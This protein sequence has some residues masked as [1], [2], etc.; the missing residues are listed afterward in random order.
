[1]AVQSYMDFVSDAASQ[2]VFERQDAENLSTETLPEN[3][4]LLDFKAFASDYP[5]KLFS[6]L[7][8][9]RPEFQEIFVEFYI[10]QKSQSF[11]ARLHGFI[12]TRAWQQL[13][14]IEQTIGALI[15]L[16]THPTES[17]IRPILEKAN[18][19]TT[20]YG[21]LAKMIVLYAATQDYVVVA[22]KIHIPVP[23]VRKLFRPIIATLL[24]D[25]DVRA[26][27]VGAYLRNLTHNASLHG[28]GLSNSCL[29]RLKRIG[30]FKFTASA[31]DQ[32]PLWSFGPIAL[33][34]DNPWYMFELASPNGLEELRPTITAQLQRACNSKTAIQVF[35]PTDPNGSLQFG[36]ILVRS[37]H[38]GI[39]RSLTKIRGISEMAARYTPEGEF[40]SA[41]TV[42]HS[43]LKDT[44]KNYKP[45]VQE[46]LRKGDFVQV[47]TGPASGYYGTIS[48]ITTR[49]VVVTVNFPTSR[50]LQ[51]FAQPTALRHEDV[52]VKQRAFWGI[53]N[54]AS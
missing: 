46:R 43:D 47:L 1:M 3:A 40:Q 16:G 17:T 22:K 31:T 30:C 13:R 51:I 38:P 32:S 20:P 18:V 45:A 35:A 29:A 11:I 49:K 42:P 26:V 34:Q 54:A 9:L 2:A 10:L 39:V 48:Q 33:L 21:S 28:A 8:Q 5:D 50:K 44:L 15:I 52:P 27:A 12:Q 41:V 25:K 4:G 36:Y 37:T 14:I 24:A 7:D 6:L 23:A 19:E 53:K